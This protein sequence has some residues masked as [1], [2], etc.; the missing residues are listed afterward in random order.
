MCYNIIS[1]LYLHYIYASVPKASAFIKSGG[2]FMLP[3]LRKINIKNSIRLKMALMTELSALVGILAVALIS[4]LSKSVAVTVIAAFIVLSIITIVIAK[5]INRVLIKP[6][7]TFS[8]RLMALAEKGDIESPTEKIAGDS[9]LS[10]LS[11]MLD[12]TVASMNGYVKNI[13]GGL[14]NIAQGKL[15]V[16]LEGE[17]IGG[18][19][20]IKTTY[21]KIVKDLSCTLSD[22]DTASCQVTTGSQQVANGAQSISQG[23]TEQA[24]SIE[25]LS[26]QISDISGKVQSSAEAAKKTTDIV[27]RTTE[28]INVCSDE[29]NNMLD[30]IKDI[31]RSSSEIAKIINVIDDIAFQT[32][33]LALN[34]AVEAARA[35]SAGKGFAVVADEVRNLAAKS[36]EAAGQTTALIQS[37]IENVEKGSKI[38]KKT[39][40]VLDGIVS[41]AREIAAEVTNISDAAAVQA[42]AIEQINTGVLQ[43]SSVIQSNTATAEES[44]AASEELSG[45]S[46]M[47]KKMLEH[48]KFDDSYA[49]DTYTPAA[50]NYDSY[51]APSYDE[52][53]T[54]AP[55]AASDDEPAPFEPVDFNN[56][57]SKKEIILDDDFL[58]VD[59]KY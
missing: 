48:F 22:I 1:V 16:P 27:N 6:L 45:Q 9:E 23:A 17:W 50:D 46:T 36:A 53:E 58:N 4:H 28:Q 47:L 35:G 14:D 42:D 19:A 3:E 37:S 15:N 10:L 11:E 52:P 26:A 32:N 13:S 29:M 54:S 33:I 55:A 39:A 20:E 30:A 25:Q 24:A 12:K 38:A 2:F 21:D 43:I 8:A 41:G 44:A 31:N 5:I 34:A 7:N 49:E 18:F 56:L 51:T 59:S 57:N 40:S